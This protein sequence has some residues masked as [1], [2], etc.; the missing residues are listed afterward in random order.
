MLVIP[1]EAVMIV[2]MT[3]GVIIVD[4]K[5]KNGMHRCITLQ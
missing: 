1:V 3:L 4:F 5:D 2:I